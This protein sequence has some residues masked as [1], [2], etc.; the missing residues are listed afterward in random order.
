MNPKRLFVGL[1]GAAV[2]VGLGAWLA[3]RHHCVG[4]VDAMEAPLSV[5][6]DLPTK[7]T[8]ADVPGAARDATCSSCIYLL[9]MCSI[10]EQVDAELAD[11]ATPDDRRRRVRATATLLD[12]ECHGLEAAACRLVV[13]LSELASRDLLPGPGGG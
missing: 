5:P 12:D 7:G 9:S 4:I 1:A 8:L 6:V 11:P 2:L 13:P 3:L 10:E